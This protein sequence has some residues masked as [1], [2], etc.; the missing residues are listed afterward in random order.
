MQRK[1]VYILL[2]LSLFLFLA[3]L[4]VFWFSHTG[5][6]LRAS[7]SDFSIVRSLEVV[8]IEIL[9]RDDYQGV[10]LEKDSEDRW[11]LNSRYY[12]NDLAVQQLLG[13]MR[14]M[15]VRT[16]V[17]IENRDNVESMLQEQGVEVNVWVRGYRVHFGNFRLFPYNRLYQSFLVGGDTPDG[18]STYMRKTRSQMAFRIHI[19]SHER[20]IAYLFDPSEREWRDPVI[21]DL[22]KEQIASVSVK[23]FENPGQSYQI[24][25]KADDSLGFFDLEDKNREILTEFDTLRFDRFLSAF[26]DVHYESL[27][28]EED[29]MMRRELMWD[30]PYMRIEVESLDGFR[31]SFTAFKRNLPAD[32]ADAEP[33]VRPDPNRL[34]IQVNEEE[35]AV[36]QYYVFNRILRPLSFFEI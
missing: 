5:S 25:R 36:A 31:A 18:Q 27:L 4:F 10:V 3:A 14:R 28:N 13:S 24:L 29:E 11:M 8:Q 9:S 20:G 19:P 15:R 35:F 21:I 33:Q 1:K 7:D 23:V 34:Y 6:T 26:R 2:F 22:R 12:A 16:P 32:T 17:S 30:E